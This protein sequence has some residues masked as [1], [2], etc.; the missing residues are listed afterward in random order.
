MYTFIDIRGPSNALRTNKTTRAPSQL[1]VRNLRHPV[2]IIPI[3]GVKF[4]S[5]AIPG[6]AYGVHVLYVSSTS[7]AERWLVG[8]PSLVDWKGN[9]HLLLAS[10]SKY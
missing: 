2:D 7:L 8:S 3:I 10:A 4:V 1:A 6:S 5:L 9:Q